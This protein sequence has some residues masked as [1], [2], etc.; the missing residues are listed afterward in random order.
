MQ[1]IDAM[2]SVPATGTGRLNFYQAGMPQ[3]CWYGLSENW[4]LKECG[5][6]HWLAMA[7]AAGQ[8]QPEFEDEQGNK[9]YAAFTFIRVSGARLYWV[10]EN[11]R[12]SIL[13][14]HCPASRTQDYSHHTVMMDGKPV[15][16]V[17]MLSVFVRR[18][19]RADNRSVVRAAVSRE[20]TV[21]AS[22]SSAA[23]VLAE[24]A[25][26]L[27]QRA[28][29][30]RA[31]VMAGSQALGL[32]AWGPNA[33]PQRLP[34]VHFSPCPNSD[35]N[36]ASL[37]YFSSFQSIT[38]RAEW[39]HREALQVNVLSPYVVKRELLFNGNVNLGDDI[40]VQMSF[41]PMVAGGTQTPVGFIHHAAL[42]RASDAHTIAHVFTRKTDA[43]VFAQSAE[44][45]VAGG[46]S[47]GANI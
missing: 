33:K 23:S 36:G 21:V 38:D 6:Q 26:R 46:L 12:F 37:L 19:V 34:L 31:A 40:V 32:S 24:S 43:S 9:V 28:K 17:E 44:A 20:S 45:L 14:R 5:H 2:Q 7:D 42:I 39:A 4:L 27:V 10:Q 13:T 35:F 8:T 18:D 47:P 25:R 30:R 11:A 3:L 29:D 41:A 1:S 22:G 16:E 15:A